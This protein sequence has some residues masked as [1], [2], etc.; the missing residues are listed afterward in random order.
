MGEDFCS[1]HRETRSTGQKSSE[2]LEYAYD[3]T[4]RPARQVQSAAFVVAAGAGSRIN[5]GN[6]GKEK[7]PAT[8]SIT[9]TWQRYNPG[10]SVCSGKSIWKITA[11]RSG[12]VTSFATTCF[13]S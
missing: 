1:L 11:L 8:S 6:R 4:G 3:F 2:R 10:L 12:A 9:F 5:N 7:L 13:D